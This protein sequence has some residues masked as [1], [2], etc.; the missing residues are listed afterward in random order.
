[1]DLVDSNEEERDE[2]ESK[3]SKGE[4]EDGHGQ[5]IIGNL[6]NDLD[7]EVLYGSNSSAQSYLLR[8]A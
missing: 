3:F 8:P 7:D 6:D 1:M 4:I 2:F 5:N